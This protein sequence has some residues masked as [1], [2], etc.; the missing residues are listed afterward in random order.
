MS[1]TQDHY[2]VLGLQRKQ[3]PSET[4]IKAAYQGKQ[5][6]LLPF[7][8]SIYMNTSKSEQISYAYEVL[9]DSDKREIYDRECRILD[10]LIY[11]E[12]LRRK[13]Y[14]QQANNGGNG[15]ITKY[16]PKVDLFKLFDGFVEDPRYED[17]GYLIHAEY[18]ARPGTRIYE[19]EKS[20]PSANIIPTLAERRTRLNQMD[21]FVA[22]GGSYKDFVYAPEPIKERTYEPWQKPEWKKRGKNSEGFLKLKKQYEKI[23]EKWK[24]GS[25]NSEHEMPPSKRATV[26]REPKAGTTNNLEDNRKASQR[27]KTRRKNE[28][29]DSA[30]MSSHERY[31]NS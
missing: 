13:A 2:K 28:K 11:Q 26:A 10:E 14:K 31:E 30:N 27:K 29:A 1:P 22:N 15:P 8:F 16:K 21:E 24:K 3:E 19:R 6:L 9:S 23:S 5:V 4:D 18:K 20:F 25:P 17:Y 12:V 7:Y